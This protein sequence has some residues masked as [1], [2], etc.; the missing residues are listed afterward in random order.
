ME[1]MVRGGSDG[2]KHENMK[3]SN[4]SMDQSAI[5]RFLW[6]QHSYH[7]PH[8]QPLV[9]N[10]IAR[11]NNNVAS[12]FGEEFSNFPFSGGGSTHGLLWPN[13]QES[14]FVDG[15]FAKE[16]ALKWTS[17]NQNPMLIMNLK[18]MHVTGKNGKD[19]GRKRTK[20]ESSMP[21]IKGQWTNEEDRF[22]RKILFSSYM[23]Y[24]FD[25]YMCAGL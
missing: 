24:L 7:I 21:L 6:G 17:I 11:S 22:E 8:H 9:E 15:L 4:F 18:D 12:V 2:A 23:H 3:E 19:I 13:T 1:V 14:C 10:N 25:S 16:E 5:D 20:K